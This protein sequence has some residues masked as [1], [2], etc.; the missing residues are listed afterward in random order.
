MPEQRIEFGVLN[1]VAQPHGAGIYRDILY[2]SA[3]REVNFWGDLNAAVREPREVEPGIFQSG[4][5]IGT[6][7]DLDEPLIDRQSYEETTAEEADVRL[8]SQHLYNGRVFLYT[9]VERTHL[10]FFEARNE[11]GKFLSPNRA[12]RIFSRLFSVEILGADFPRVDVTVVPEDD[13]LERLLGIKRLDKVEIYLQRPNP[14]DTHP[15]EVNAILAELEE[16]GAKNQDISLTRAPGAER[17][18]LNA[19][20]YVRAKVA[21]F[22]GFV[23]TSGVTEDG[24]RF[25]GST[26]SHPKIVKA[27]VDATTS[28]RSVAL[29]IAR[30][31]RIGEDP[32]QDGD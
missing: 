28:V 5:V 15:D 20:N 27:I 23:R 26:K 14:A 29:R 1:I 4:I 30:H 24:E 18:V 21:Q 6:E 2:R 32:P 16:Q 3:N 31:T 19:A 25:A 12:H 13:T 22:N 8:S 10:L 11:F 17:I 9:F 7:I